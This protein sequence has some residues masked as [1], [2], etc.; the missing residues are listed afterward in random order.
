MKATKRSLL[1][2]LCVAILVVGALV[3]SACSKECAHTWGDWSETTA[4]TCIAEGTETRTCSACGETETRAI[5]TVAHNFSTYTPDGNAT[6]IADGT[7][8]ATCTTAG[9]N[10]KDTVAD[11]DSKTPH[12]FTEYTSNGDATCQADGTKTATCATDGCNA[13]ETVTDTGSKKAH[14]FTTYHS[15]NNATCQ[16]DGT[17]TATCDYFGCTE[18]DT[19]TDTGSK[20]THSFTS[21]TSNGDATCV[22][23]GTKTAV[24][25]FDGCEERDT[26][27]DEGSKLGHD[28]D[29]ELTCTTGHVC[30][31]VGCDAE[32]AALG[33]NYTVVG[34]TPLTCEQDSTTIYACQNGCSD[35]FT[36]TNALAPG[37]AV[38]EWVFDHEEFIGECTYVLTYA[39]ICANKSCSQ[40][41]YKTEQAER[42]TLKSAI[43]T[44]ATCSTPGKKL[45]TCS[46]CSYEA[47]ENYTNPDAHVWT[48]KS[49]DGNVTTYECS[50]CGTTKTAITA[51][52]QTETTVDKDTLANVGE[53][54][55]KDASIALDDKTLGGLEGEVQISA[56]TLEG[57]DL[58]A[59][60]GQLGDKLDQIGN[61]PIYNFGLNDANGAV[62]NFDGWVTIRVPYT[63]EDGEDV[64]SIAV[65]F[66]NEKGEVES[67]EATYDNGYAVFSTNHFSY[68]T[69]TRLTPAERCELYGHSYKETVV[70]ATCV[71]DGYTLKVCQRCGHS[72]KQIT[73]KAT[74]HTITTVTTP[75]TCTESGSATHSC[76][77]CDYERVE[78]IAPAGHTWSV[79][80]SEEAT[81]K[82]AGFTVYTCSTCQASYKT[83]IAQKAH[84]YTDTVTKATCTTDGYTTRVCEWCQYTVTVNKIAALGHDYKTTTV[85]NGCTTEGYTLHDCSRCDSSY[86]TDIIPPSHT[87]DIAQPTCGKGQ[88]CIVCGAGG[89]S[90]TG[91]HTMENGICTVCGTGCKHTFNAVVTD[92]TCTEVGFTTNTCTACGV[93]EKTDYKAALGHSGALVCT[94]CG[95]ETVPEDYYTNI[96]ESLLNEQYTIVI[97]SLKVEDGIEVIDS[98][99]FVSIAEGLDGYGTVH[100]KSYGIT[101]TFRAF[102]DDGYVYLCG[103]DTQSLTQSEDVYM[104]APLFSFASTMG[105]MS[106]S[107]YSILLLS[108]NTEAISWINDTAIPFLLNLTKDGKDEANLVAK[109]VVELIAD[110]EA[111]DGDLVITPSLEKIKA[112]NARLATETVSQIVDAEFGEGAYDEFNSKVEAFFD[113][114][115]GELIDNAKANGAD[116]IALIDSIDAL[117]TGIA[118]EKVTISD[119]MELEGSLQDLLKSDELRATTVSELADML[120]KG[121][122]GEE[123]HPMPGE[124]PKEDVGDVV[125][126]PKSKDIVTDG[127][128]G[129][130]YVEPTPEEE[131]SIKSRVLEIIKQL[132]D[133]TVYEA[134]GYEGTDAETVKAV[135]DKIVEVFEMIDL[136]VKTDRNGTLLSV[137]LVLK[138][139]CD[140]SIVADYVST[141]DYSVIKDTAN[142]KTDITIDP[143]YVTGTSGNYNYVF[144]ID[145]DGKI[146]GV[147]YEY[148]SNHK[149]P[150]K[151]GDTEGGKKVEYYLV[152]S[153]VTN[154]TITSGINDCLIATHSDCGDWIGVAISAIGTYER[155]SSYYLEVYENGV[156]VETITDPDVINK[157]AGFYFSGGE[158]E[159]HTSY[160]SV[161]FFLNPKT[162]EIAN[163]GDGDTLHAYEEDTAKHKPAVGCEGVGERHYFCTAC[164]ETMVISY[165]NGHDFEWTYELVDG[166][167]SCLDGII[168]KYTCTECGKVNSQSIMK[169]YHLGVGQ[170][171][172]LSGFGVCS[173]HEIFNDTCVCG[174][175][176]Y[177]HHYGLDWLYDNTYGCRE[178]GLTFSEEYTMTPGEGCTMNVITVIVIAKNG[179]TIYTSTREY[180]TE[181]HDHRINVTLLPGSTTCEDGVSV[182]E[183]CTK[184][185]MIT[186]EYTEYNHVTFEKVIADLGQYG[187]VCGTYIYTYGCACGYYDKNDQI[188]IGGKCEF[189]QVNEYWNDW[190]DNLYKYTCAVT[191][192]ACGFTLYE[193]AYFTETVCGRTCYR[194]YYTIDSNG[195]KVVIYNCVT[196]EETYHAYETADE[197]K[198]P[199]EHPCLWYVVRTERC[200]KCGHTNEYIGYDF[201]H[202]ERDHTDGWYCDNCDHGHHYYYDGDGNC[203][204]QVSVFWNVNGDNTVS[205][206]TEEYN[207]MYYLD[208][209][210]E[211]LYFASFEQYVVNGMKLNMTSSDWSRITRDYDFSGVCQVTETFESSYKGEEYTETRK[212]CVH[213]THSELIPATCTQPGVMAQTCLIC[214]NMTTYNTEPYCHEWTWYWK[215]ECYVCIRC[216][217]KNA[218]G[219]S[220]AIVL[221]DASDL[222]GDD[223]TYIIGYYFRDFGDKYE[224]LYAITLVNEWGE[225]LAFIDLEEFGIEITPWGDGNYITF[226]KSAVI[227]AAKQLGFSEDQYDIRLSFVPIGWYDDLDYAITF[228]VMSKTDDVCTD[229]LEGRDGYCVFCGEKCVDECNHWY[230]DGWCE[231]CGQRDPNYY[232]CKH[233]YVDGWCEYCGRR[234]PNYTDDCKHKFDEK[235]YCVLCGFYNGGDG[236]FHENTTTQREKPTCTESGRKLVICADC[237]IVLSEDY[238]A[239]YGHTYFDGICKYCGQYENIGGCEEH[240]FNAMGVCINCGYG[241][242]VV[243]C[244]H[245]DLIVEEMPSNCQ[246]GGYK[247][248]RCAKCGV[249]VYE[250]HWAPTEHQYGGGKCIFC[251]QPEGGEAEC[252][253]KFDEKGYCVLCGFYKGGND[254]NH[255]NVRTENY[256]ATCESFGYIRNFCNDCGVM[257]NSYEIAPYGHNY[258]GGYCLKCGAKEGEIVEPE[259]KVLYVYSDYMEEHDEKGNVV[260]WAEITVSLCENKMAYYVLT[261]YDCI[262]GTQEVQKLEG[263]WQDWH[264][265]DGM[266]I[267]RVCIDMIGNPSFYLNE[268]GELEIYE[269][270]EGGDA[271][272]CPHENTY[273]DR[274]AP[275]CTAGGYTFIY[276][277]DCGRLLSEKYLDPYGHRFD[278]G[279]CKY[280]GVTEEEAEICKEHVDY[281]MNGWCDKCGTEVGFINNCK[282]EEIYVEEKMPSCTEPGYK[283]E[284]CGK[285]DII[286]YEEHWAQSEHWFENGKCVYCGT[287]E[288]EYECQHL[289][290]DKGYCM[291]CGFFGGSVEGCEHPEFYTEETSAT[292][293]ADGTIRTICKVC[294]YI[295]NEI[296]IPK[297]GH[298]FEDGRCVWCGDSEFGDE[299]N[300]K[301]DEM[302]YCVLCGYYAGNGEVII[303]EHKEILHDE[304]P[305]TCTDMGYSRE[306]CAMCGIVLF[307]EYWEPTGHFFEGSKCMNCGQPD[308][309]YAGEEGGVTGSGT[310]ED[311]YVISAF[312]AELI[313]GAQHDVYVTYTAKGTQTIV[314]FY[315]QGCYVSGLPADAVK[316]AYT[317]TY[318]FTLEAGTTITFNLWTSGIN[319]YTYTFELI[320]STTPDDGYV[321]GEYGEGEYGCAHEYDENGMCVICGKFFKENDFVVVG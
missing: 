277:S 37:H 36:V 312:P 58:D 146:T 270:N 44:D 304:C 287:E 263:E 267:F 65:W 20:K 64:D 308:D 314:I 108:T 142:E 59:V 262:T 264:T 221:E 311:P 39:G 317:M 145:K 190:C 104:K 48:V 80:D 117:L 93:V 11:P 46:G 28:W 191:K 192:P 138:D 215:D 228:E 188:S 16:A 237:G 214:S 210:F 253:H 180:T 212:G 315:P 272:D 151:L 310:A 216:G 290:N 41:V 313:L 85:P 68:Y 183:Y 47:Y 226:S 120:F 195:G 31:R 268:K 118:G 83:V 4:A 139:F 178:C 166:A 205:K 203:I 222:D 223:D 136:T 143:N 116:V 155:T 169:G 186:H 40:T 285:C 149:Q 245:P 148:T 113:R 81:C 96:L 168:E 72:A 92:P 235:G 316:D 276:C 94:V 56:G 239:P 182:I 246:S 247:I 97:D 227:N 319:T 60:I 274:Q 22:L 234:D 106:A 163:F 123:V 170:K 261:L 35:M 122:G 288:G 297:T 291:W 43:H 105:G 187:S 164:G 293:Y 128:V 157:L 309:P 200:A 133:M 13:T 201:I 3:L 211:T 271:Y 61:N 266:I 69:V 18:T 126:T 51:T 50:E 174:E 150:F 177:I 244:K 86:K 296:Y 172:D 251:G 27:E 198:N 29:K 147:W 283:I 162:G 66:I 119:L 229:H 171:I 5:S 57:K 77:N 225:E 289:F 231:Y 204:R 252:A 100:I 73:G 71:T 112:L 154:Y 140:I 286:V 62:S 260:M 78:K 298:A 98:E 79:T 2:L 295:S 220:G 189:E 159:S 160:I 207:W 90:A 141:F 12:V 300:H 194:E 181:N 230:V 269:G 137:D 302:G 248:E 321:D 213:F 208:Y 249:I 103:E 241:G 303:C 26:I 67:I 275:N 236:C 307:E 8:T 294:G 243:D 6:C 218:N 233:W 184:C 25:D 299:C 238:L 318:T 256:D 114:T 320:A 232:E 84:S 7:K 109:K 34:G 281:D 107:S 76:A 135:E 33:H 219:A 23:D 175:N 278:N 292:C 9:C 206:S 99:I 273:T 176:S 280:C 49:V 82:K 257:I 240:I 242:E 199:T 129:G 134:M 196:S 265:M 153:S 89:Q 10:A 197:V 24:C 91:N 55:L 167:T 70:K 305:A 127:T 102:I 125:I 21:Y 158:E 179:E 17:K 301:F 306:F 19:V 75:A 284:R 224:F 185:G 88:T 52:E 259:M 279:A 152:Q 202:S 115:L 121:M 101:S 42:H 156:L 282:H 255:E 124:P 258:E 87:W 74:G 254:C 14:A 193:R 132:K 30:T 161:L 111:V 32:E 131:T 95:A 1:L 63:L 130:D 144:E 209:S 250:E 110:V 165:T 15:D 54:E 53:V 217:L 45:I 38:S 173:H